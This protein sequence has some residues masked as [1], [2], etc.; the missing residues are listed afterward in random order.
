M[1]PG[2]TYSPGEWIALVSRTAAVLIDP[3]VPSPVL[4]TLWRAVDAGQGLDAA[5]DLLV[6]HTAPQSFDFALA[7]REA[8]SVR[9]VIGGG[10]ELTVQQPS[11][12]ERVVRGDGGRREERAALDDVLWF[13]RPGGRSD[14]VA[15]PIAVGAVLADMLSWQSAEPAPA[16]GRMGLV[17][18]RYAA[19]GVGTPR[20]AAST[21]LDARTVLD[22]PAQGHLFAAPASVAGR[23]GDRNGDQRT[24]RSPGLGSHPRRR[25]GPADWSLT[26]HDVP[27]EVP[28]HGIGIDTAVPEI[29]A[30][31]PLDPVA[32]RLSTAPRGRRA[33][34]HTSVP[35]ELAPPPVQPAEP[36][37]SVES[38]PVPAAAP[39][40]AIPVPVPPP[41]DQREVEWSGLVAPETIAPETIAPEV[42]A[43]EVLEPE[44]LAPELEPEFVPE[45]VVPED[46]VPDVV[47]PEDVIAGLVAPAVIA[48]D[49]V[50][51]QVAAPVVREPSREDAEQVRSRP[52]PAQPFVDPFADPVSAEPSDAGDFSWMSPAQPAE[53]GWTAEQPWQAEPQPAEPVEPEQFWAPSEQPAPVAAEP[54]AQVAPAAPVAP[55]Q[56]PPAPPV[57]HVEPAQP[58]VTSTPAVGGASSALIGVLVFS[59]G[60][61]VVVDGPVIIGRAPSQTDRDRPARLVTVRGEGRGVSRNH[62]RIDVGTTGPFAIDLGSRNGSTLTA[63]GGEQETMNS[64]MPYP[65]QPGSQL[66]VA[67]L[68]CYYRA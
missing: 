53:T 11:G 59:D 42:L 20:S 22:A 47:A 61:E 31:L 15:L 26:P 44:V 3:E 40:A 6:E 13:T 54:T 35:A 39:T 18:G 5:L 50:E 64:W 33:A 12:S 24:R 41:V 1:T 55:P 38:A 36:L 62:L 27:E 65:L 7:V 29:R 63:P 48:P 52:A 43:P 46:F 19:A 68:V 14:G 51:A 57:E 23:P 9:L 56:A 49:V 66:T 58:E 34:R 37:S 60:T 25:Y 4:D 32:E 10:L 28:T 16:P 30:G 21:R 67:D 8:E 2:A 45:D 17:A